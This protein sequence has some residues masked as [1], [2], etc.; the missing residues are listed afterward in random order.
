MCKASDLVIMV[1]DSDEESLEQSCC[2]LE[3]LG[4]DKDKIIC[5]KTF[6][7]ALSAL[8]DNGDID[9][10]LADFNLENSQHF[11]TLLCASIKK[12]IPGMLV[13]LTSKEYSCSVVLDSFKNG[14]EDILD[15]KREG[16]IEKLMGKWI[17][18]AKQR[19]ITRELLYGSA[20]E[21]R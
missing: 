20:Q 13:I 7:Q 6:E 11:G 1:V 21:R 3:S 19:V 17:H 16:E 14:A 18:L 9:I 4:V 15:L 10:V 12:K 8:N 5:I 2:S